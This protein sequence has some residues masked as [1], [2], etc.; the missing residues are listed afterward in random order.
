MPPENNLD[1]NRTSLLSDCGAANFTEPLEKRVLGASAHSQMTTC[2][3]CQAGGVALLL[4]AL[5]TYST[6]GPFG[7][8]SLILTAIVSSHIFLYRILPPDNVKHY[9]VLLFLT[10]LLEYVAL[11]NIFVLVVL[12]ASFGRGNEVWVALC[13]LCQ[14]LAIYMFVH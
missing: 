12:K 1:F 13:A 8:V 11:Y 9:L 14:Q 3:P 2:F 6:F 10:L 4:T 7:I 5:G